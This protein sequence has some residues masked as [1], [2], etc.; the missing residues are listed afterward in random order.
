MNTWNPNDWSLDLV[1]LRTTQISCAVFFCETLQPAACQAF[2]GAAA[3][4]NASK[5]S[6]MSN[7]TK[8]KEQRSQAKGSHNFCWDGIK[9]S[10]SHSLL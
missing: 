8:A 9:I 2:L 4:D 3:I 5:C 10:V 6:T 7:S 1:F